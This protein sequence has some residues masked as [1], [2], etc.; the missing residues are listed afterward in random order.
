MN[1][2]L[3]EKSRKNGMEQ[4][5][6]IRTK[7]KKARTF[8]NMGFGEKKGAWRLRKTGCVVAGY[9][10]AKRLRGGQNRWE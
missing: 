2:V 3:I 10:R 7:A 6:N 1:G 5:A 9:R 8:W 4:Q